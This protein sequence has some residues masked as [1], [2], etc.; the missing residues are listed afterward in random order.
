MKVK[1]SKKNDGFTLIEVLIALLIL[2]I[3]ILAFFKFYIAIIRANSLNS[4]IITATYLAES[5]MNDLYT[6]QN[7]SSGQYSISGTNNIVYKIVWK[8]NK[9]QNKNNIIV[10]CK[11]KQFGQ[12][13]FVKFST[14]KTSIY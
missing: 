9:N 7:L 8:I 12:E 3:G 14:V 11:W 1:F 13:H 6:S 10:T 5:K 2:L 4:S